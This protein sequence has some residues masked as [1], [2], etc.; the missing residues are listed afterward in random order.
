MDSMYNIDV[1]APAVRKK[2]QPLVTAATTSATGDQ[3]VITKQASE[4][5]GGLNRTAPK[6]FTGKRNE[7]LVG[8]Y[9]AFS[10]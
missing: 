5:G 8:V 1:L 10:C 4:R 9:F 2:Q 6:L 3:A 7:N